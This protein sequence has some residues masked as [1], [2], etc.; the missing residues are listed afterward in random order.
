MATTSRSERFENAI[1]DLQDMT[2]T[3]YGRD[4]AK[5]YSI[6]ELLKRWDGVAGI[7][8]TINRDIPLP[9]DGRDE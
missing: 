6:P 4:Y 9:P 8:L 5:S 7:S 3:E 1:I 2:I